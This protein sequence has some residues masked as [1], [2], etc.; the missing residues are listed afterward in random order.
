MASKYDKVFGYNTDG[1]VVDSAG[2]LLELLDVEAFRAARAVEL[3]LQEG[4]VE[5]ALNWCTDHS[6]KLNRLGS[7]LDFFLRQEQVLHVIS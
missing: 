7:V 1:C 3:Q 2:G 4:N 5:L 6:S